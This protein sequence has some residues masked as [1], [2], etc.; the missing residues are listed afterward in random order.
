M[1]DTAVLAAGH[2][3]DNIS[4][5]FDVPKAPIGYADKQKLT[6]AATLS[7]QVAAQVHLE[8]LTFIMNLF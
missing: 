1:A 7:A 8:V 5:W 6:R 4:E 3:Y 2:A